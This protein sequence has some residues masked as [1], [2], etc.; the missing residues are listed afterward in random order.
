VSEFRSNGSAARFRP[1]KPMHYSAC[2]TGWGSI[3]T[4]YFRKSSS[5]PILKEKAV[6]SPGIP[7]E[8]PQKGGRMKYSQYLRGDTF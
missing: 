5:I 6:K 7:C 8:S 3:G 1:I 2:G 4:W